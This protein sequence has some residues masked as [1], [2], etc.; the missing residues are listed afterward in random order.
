VPL[1]PLVDARRIVFERCEQLPAVPVPL[2]DALGLVLAEPIIARE[3]I[4]PWPNSAVDGFAVVA[5]GVTA[6]P[7]E[8]RI[9]G[10]L[11]AGGSFDA[12]VGAGEA[13][14]LMTGAPMPAGA[15][16]VVMVEDTSASGD[17]VTLNRVPKVGDGI[18]LAGSDVNDGDLVF[19][20]GTVL[21]PAHLGVLASLGV[22]EPRVVR[23]ARVAVL[24]TGDELVEGDAPLGPG[25]IRDSNRRSLIALL[26]QA[27]VTAID[28]GLIRDDEAALEAVL[29]RA[30]QECDAIVT[31][32]GVSMGDF[33]VVKAVLGRIAEMQWM[34]V[35]IKPAKPFAFGLLDSVPVFG[36]PGNPVSS[37][38]SFELFARPALRQM[39]GYTYIDR[40][41][42]AALALEPL[43]RHADG[44]T[45]FVRVI[46]APDADGRLTVRSAGGQASH[47]LK[48]MADANALVILPDGDGAEAGAVVNC[49]L[50]T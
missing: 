15:D 10:T 1:I 4:P 35:A 27:D 43:G 44:K 33:D 12:P 38:V 41:T 8:L 29:R 20:A 14:R 36:L 24:S 25:Q 2:S 37:L 5:S 40:L 30:A 18:R 32:G 39:M 47:H 48:A 42:L 17:T 31:S 21:G 7:A 11:A 23:R 9:I 19:P 26:G 13:L 22:Y 28:Y 46:A 3:S 6:V 34:Q 50:L 45:H 16:A 49:L